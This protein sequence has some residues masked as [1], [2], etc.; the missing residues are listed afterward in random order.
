ARR[1]VG[2]AAM[3]DEAREGEAAADLENLF[4]RRHRP[5]AEARREQRARRPEQSEQG[6]RGRRD[7]EPLGSAV[8]IGELVPVEQRAH[9]EVVDAGD[10]YPLLLGPVAWH[11]GARGGW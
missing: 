5:R 11:R 1:H 3:S 10:R 6:P 9:D 2:A 4:A 7:A 8:A